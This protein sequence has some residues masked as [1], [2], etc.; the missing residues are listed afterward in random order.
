MRIHIPILLRHLHHR[1][2]TI[3]LL[4]VGP[5][6]VNAF[7][8]SAADWPVVSR[9]VDDEIVMITRANVAST[10]PFFKSV[11][12]LVRSNDASANDREPRGR[13]ALILLAELDVGSCYCYVSLADL[14]ATWPYIVV[15]VDTPEKIPAVRERLAGLQ[16]KA[17]G[18]GGSDHAASPAIVEAVDGGVLICWEERQRQRLATMRTTERTDLQQGLAEAA[19]HAAGF[20]V[21][22]SEDQRR[23]VRELFAESPPLFGDVMV[24]GIADGVRWIA[25]GVD[26]PPKFSS[27]VVVCGADSIAAQQIKTSLE[28]GIAQVEKLEAAYPEIK[29]ATVP[30]SPW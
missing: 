19:N 10:G 18:S 23:V 21:S 3:A 17:P 9:Y 8:V 5:N 16:W 26:V 13:D 7:E 24:K 25:V 1:W 29:V 11:Q 20:V 22:F 2:L 27:R 12:N 30:L 15:P 14:P 4:C 28:L 6:N